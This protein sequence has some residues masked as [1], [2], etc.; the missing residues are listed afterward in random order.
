MDEEEA[1]PLINEHAKLITQEPFRYRHKW[2][3]GD[4]LMWDNC[5][6]QHLATFD[7]KWPEERRLIWRITVG[8]TKTM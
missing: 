7:Y 8:G 2:Q 5:A 1:V 3:V 4:V 6:V